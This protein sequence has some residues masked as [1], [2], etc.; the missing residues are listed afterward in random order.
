MATTGLFTFFRGVRNLFSCGTVVSTFIIH[1]GCGAAALPIVFTTKSY[2]MFFYTGLIHN[3]KISLISASKRCRNFTAAENE[4]PWTAAHT[5]NA[6]D[7]RGIPYC[8]TTCPL[9]T[10]EA[11]AANHADH[12]SFFGE[13]RRSVRM[14]TN[15]FGTVGCETH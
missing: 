12:A 2:F 6:R 9:V 11:W 10:M 7:T 3:Y 13:T 4:R 1:R 5:Y 14:S 8:E 15:Q